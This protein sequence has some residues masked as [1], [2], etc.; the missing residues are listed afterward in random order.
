M[1]QLNVVQCGLN[2]IYTPQGYRLP[3]I[4]LYLSGQNESISI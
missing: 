4:R 3:E 2:N 1:L